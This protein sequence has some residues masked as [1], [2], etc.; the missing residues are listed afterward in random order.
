MPGDFFITD[1]AWG[2]E[3]F[4]RGLSQGECADEWNLSHPMEVR[5]VAEG[6]VESGAEIILTNTF[7]ANRIAL[8]RFGLSSS[9]FAINTAGVAI[10]RRAADGRARVFAS[11]GP[12]GRRPDRAGTTL[13]AVRAAFAEQAAILADSGAHGLVLETFT[14]PEE[15]CIA[16]RAALPTGLPVVVSLFFANPSSHIETAA[17]T[18]AQE[19]ASVVGANCSNPGESVAICRRLRQ[20]TDLPLWIKPSAGLP[21]TRD[22]RLTFPVTSA[23]F[24]AHAKSIRDAGATYIGGCCGTNPQFVR[25]LATGLKSEKHSGDLS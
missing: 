16:L 23:E 24:A 18:L 4:N 7:R 1:G 25:A 22:S 5:A 11:M 10:S 17:V 15:A 20:S 9:V 12:T 3:L 8:E 14:D 2:C 6:Y 21:V 13:E 19:G